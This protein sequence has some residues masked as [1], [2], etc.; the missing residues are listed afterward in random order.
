MIKGSGGGDSPLYARLGYSTATFPPLDEASWRDPSDNAI[1]LVDAEGRRT[2]RTGM[3]LLALSAEPDAGVAASRAQAHWLDAAPDQKHHGSGYEG[4][5]RSAGTITMVSLVRC[6][7]EI[8][9]ARVDDATEDARV[10]VLTGWPTTDGDGLVSLIEVL[11]G[12][13]TTVLIEDETVHVRW[14]DAHATH[15][16]LDPLTEGA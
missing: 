11:L 4:E 10:L 6:A 7:W 8:R 5:A 9:L 2:H 13:G 15:L 3:R 12:S 14:P 1:C 16:A